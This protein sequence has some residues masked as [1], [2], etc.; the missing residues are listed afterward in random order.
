MS[1]EE[2]SPEQTRQVWRA[3]CG[4][5]GTRVVRKRDALEMRATAR[6]LA[7]VGVL[8]A[9]SFMAR[10]TTVWGRRI[11]TPF[12]PGEGDA[13]ARWS[14]I[15]ICAHE[16]QHVEQYARAGGF[17]AYA[18]GY[19]LSARRRALLEAEA[20]GCNMELAWWRYGV[21]P[22]PSLLANTLR[23]YGCGDADIEAA[24]EALAER[25]GHLDG[26]GGPALAASLAAIEAC[27]ESG[28]GGALSRR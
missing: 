4:R 12:E 28:L 15:V 22:D 13:E 11:Y 2:P 3:L 27:E 8:P 24:R 19:L 16:H 26:G 17:A 10:F 23:N 1:L 9:D 6:A 21:I 7:F 5:Y 20:Y 18:P 25:A 14:Q